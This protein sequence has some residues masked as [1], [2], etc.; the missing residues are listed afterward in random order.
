MLKPACLRSETVLRQTLLWS[1]LA[2]VVSAGCTGGIGGA[3][4]LNEASLDEPAFDLA[5][6]SGDAKTVFKVDARGLGEKYNVTWDWGDG[7]FSYGEEAE[8]KYGFSDGIMT[9]TLVAT[10]DDGAQGIATKEVKLG[11]G[12]NTPPTISSARASKSWVEVGKQINL[13]AT[14]SDKDRDPL[15]YTWSYQAADSP[16][17]RTIPG[18]GNRVPVTF[19]APGKYSIKVRARDPK[20]GEAVSNLTVDV[21]TTIP[22]TRFEQIFNGTLVA[23]TGGASASERLW[24]AGEAGAPDTN[25]DVARHRY[26]LEYPANTLVFLTWNDTAAQ[27]AGQGVQDLD[28]E[29][30]AADGTVVFKSETRGPPNIPYEFNLTRQEAGDYDVIVRGIVAANIT[31]SVV[32]QATLQITPDM[33]AAREAAG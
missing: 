12:Q 6:E 13:S 2:A 7:T 15:K 28:L 22:S 11:T 18:E 31:Y 16:A 25:V 21:S 17:E 9:I 24:P 4:S 32:V 27:T 30:R 3:L 26:T 33:V 10:D 29:L 8:H 5:P 23:G 14:A 20:G 1:I 19:D